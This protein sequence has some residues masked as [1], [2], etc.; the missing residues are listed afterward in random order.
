MQ[1]QRS[2]LYLA[3]EYPMP[4]NAASRLRTFNWLLHLSKRFRV[5]L[6]APAFHALSDMESQAL[7]GRCQ[8][9]VTVAV[10]GRPQVRRLPHRVWRALRHVFTGVPAEAQALVRGGIAR[11]VRH[12]LRHHRYDVAFAEHWAQVDLAHAAAPFVML[13]AGEL[14]T[15]RQVEAL[16]FGGAALRRWGASLWA[17]M[18]ERAEADALARFHLILLNSARARQ[19]VARVV[20][21]TGT[22]LVLPDGL[23]T[24]HFAPQRVSFN[25]RR[26]VFHSS[27]VSFNQQDALHHLRAHLLPRVRRCFGDVVLT[28]ITQRCPAPLREQLQAD[29]DV[30]FLGAV[31]DPRPI[32]QSAAV[33]VL[34][35]RLGR[36][37]RSRLIQLLSLGVPTVATPLATAGLDVASGDGLLLA[38]GEAAFADAMLQVLEDASL[39]RDLAARGRA[40]AEARLSLHATYGHLTDVLS[41]A[42]LDLHGSLR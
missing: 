8:R 26:V 16:R 10:H 37:S 34:P 21:D 38:E 18:Q 25:P 19:E 4:L 29:P 2:L 11:E 23:N 42:S 40:L 28:V 36:G 7:D 35:L 39:R 3:R 20:G 15:A 5:T 9:I 12:L 1:A 22:M 27:L 31:E 13:D 14:Q 32:L 6:V 24:D 17:G 33:A 30:E 41:E